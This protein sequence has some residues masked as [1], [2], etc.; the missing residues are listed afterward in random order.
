MRYALLADQ[1]FTPAGIETGSAVIVEDGLIADVTSSIPA[2]CEVVRLAGQSIMPGFVDIHI[3]GRNGFDVMDATDTALQSISD[4]LPQTGVVAWV[5]T[6][7]TAPWQDIIDA[8]AAVRQFTDQPQQQGAELLGSFLEGPYFTEPHRGSHPPAF[9]KAPTVAELE[10]L[11]ETAGAS[12]LR[13]ALAPE[14]EGAMDAISWLSAQHIKPSV[15][16]TDATYAQVTEAHQRGADCGVHLFNGM[17]GLHHREP[18]CCGAVLYHDM[19]AELIADGVHVNP[20][21]MNLAYR[22]KG[23]RGIALITDCMR[24]GG[25]S[26]GE[27]QLGAQ[28]ISVTNGEA[29]SPCGSLAGSTCSL[30]QAV[31]NMVNLTGV[32]VWEA[33][34]MASYVPA[35]YLGLAERLG[36]VAK[37]MEAS[38]TM[39]DADLQV[40]G[41]M[42]KGQW[43]FKA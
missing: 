6:T 18:G 10:Q 31:R 21:M 9:L 3:H 4:A 13:A 2:D 14:S 7:V 1:V 41:T 39:M 12:L 26:D 25:L 15:A 30:D 37:G 34:Q 35:V 28:M 38:L 40:Q 23:Y 36:S 8:L 42:I 29:R 43:A 17:R 22:I 24:A 19:L 11:K 32:P 20:V 27:Y 5:G 33:V 16:H